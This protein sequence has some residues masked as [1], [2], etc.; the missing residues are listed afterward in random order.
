MDKDPPR[1]LSLLARGPGLSLG[2]EATSM[3]STS[4]LVRPSLG[5]LSVVLVSGR[6][7]GRVKRDRFFSL[8]ILTFYGE[9]PCTD[10]LDLH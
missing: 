2:I 3:G 9:W 10:H 4:Q 6:M 7:Y 8:A 5:E 1:A